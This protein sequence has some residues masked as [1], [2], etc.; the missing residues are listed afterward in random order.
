MKI[1][2][3]SITANV[4]MLKYR[5][6][7]TTRNFKNQSTGFGGLLLRFFTKWESGLSMS[8]GRVM[9]PSNVFT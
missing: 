8:E 6:N 4:Q 2:V 7:L 5:V 9:G 3:D 1:S